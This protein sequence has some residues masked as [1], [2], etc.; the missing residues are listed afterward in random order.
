[1]ESP[2]NA[3]KSLIALLF[4]L[5]ACDPGDVALLAPDTPD[6]DAPSTA[7]HVVVDTP[8]AAAGA[9]LGWSGSVPGSEVRVHRM[10]EPYGEPYWAVA[11]TDSTGVAT[12][13]GVLSG[14]YELTVHRP[15]GAAE[16]EAV[17]GAFRILAGGLRVYLPSAS[18]VVTVAPDHRGSILFSEVG[19]THPLPWDVNY[20][21]ARYFEVYNNGDTTVFLDGKYWGLGFRYNHDYPAWPCAA[22]E[23]VRNDPDGVWTRVVFRFPGAGTDYPLQPG[24]VAL[25]ANAAV[26]HRGVHPLMYD[27]S[28]ADFEWGGASSAD[29]PD[30]PNLEDVGLE[31]MH[32]FYPLDE[33]P[34]FLS[35]PVELGTLPRWVDPYTGKPWVRIPKALVLDAWVDVIDWTTHN[36][37][38]LDA[39]L[40]VF[41]RSFERLPG[42]AAMLMDFYDALS[43]QRRV[44][45]VLPDGRK[46]LQDSDTSMEDFVNAPRTPGW[47]ADSLGRS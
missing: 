27:L 21:D 15:L 30:V 12:F 33:D 47:I 31:P 18:A 2:G 13:R 24:E 40:E 9:A 6:G 7:I 11:A 10:N 37:E 17:Q 35:E 14:L 1:M 45:A 3:C 26:D 39:C 4:L 42:P 8:Y 20:R 41:H 28:H 46:V 25:I 29:N 44:L 34:F 16:V 43:M 19:L 22:T 5:A 23:V 32:F 38:P 36:Y